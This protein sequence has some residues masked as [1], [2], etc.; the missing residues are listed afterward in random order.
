MPTPHFLLGAGLVRAG[1]ANLAA[2]ER[3]LE[4]SARLAEKHDIGES[5]AISRF[6]LGNVL[7]ERG[8]LP[9][10]IAAYHQAA[11]LARAAGDPGHQVLALNNLAYHT[12]LLGETG[13]AKAHIVA[14]LE[15]AE[16]YGLR[17]MLEYLF[18]TRG[19]IAIAEDQM[20]EAEDWIKRSLDVARER[21]NAAHVAKCQAN[22][23]RIA[24]RRGDLDTALLQLEE[25]AA[26]AAAL[27]AR[28][29]QTQIDL[30]LGEL[31]ATRGERIA[32]FEALSRA[33][34]RLV[35]NQY[36]QLIQRAKELRARL[37]AHQ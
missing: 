17:L 16:A 12:M 32:A 8:D 18:S 21:N 30:W 37:G 15:L 13:A 35:D 34:D 6:E 4:E 31:Y 20:D 2:A 33:E 11:G 29:L 25:A 10:A 7:A 22:L 27:T 3:H 24:H 28:Y 1:G 9:A 5:A 14:A 23:G 36:G 19:E 26:S